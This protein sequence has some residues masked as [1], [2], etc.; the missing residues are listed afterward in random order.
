M[1]VVY[2]LTIQSDYTELRYSLRSI[3]KYLKFDEVVIVG[4]YIP[5]WINNVTQIHIPD[6]QGQNNYS[7]RRKVIAALHYVDDFLF[8]NDDFYLLKPVKK[9]FPYYSSGTLEGKAEAGA[10]PLLKRLKD[11]NK[12]VKYYGHYPA[13]YRKDF[14]EIMNNFPNECITKSAYLN[15]IEPES[16]EISDCKILTAKKESFVREFIKDRPCFS[17]GLYSINSALPVLNELF[18]E[19]SIFEI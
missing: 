8:F 6:V 7:V 14:T 19:P 12:P 11:L 4:D 9:D 2:P 15:F 10:R 1:T 17:T 5:D 13:L 3:E 16:I 18:P